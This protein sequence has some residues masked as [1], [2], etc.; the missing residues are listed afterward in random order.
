MDQ[1]QVDV[2]ETEAG[3]RLVERTAYVV[4]PVVGVVE[5][6]GHEQFVT[7]D[8]GAGDRLADAFSLP[9]IWAVSMWR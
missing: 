6:G 7:G 8:A 5:L 4:G 3:Q 9:Y 2:I 1:E